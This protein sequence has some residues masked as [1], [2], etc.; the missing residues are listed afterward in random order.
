M[1][2]KIIII[3]DIIVGITGSADIG[4]TFIISVIVI[5]SSRSIIITV[6]MM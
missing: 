4:I 5:T 1:E 3:V 2:I 6:V